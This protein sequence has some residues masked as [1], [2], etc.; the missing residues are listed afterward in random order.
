MIGHPIIHWQGEPGSLGISP[1]KLETK[2]DGKVYRFCFFPKLGLANKKSIV[3]WKIVNFKGEV[4]QMKLNFLGQ[5]LNFQLF[6]ITYLVGI[7]WLSEFNF[8]ILTRFLNTTSSM[9]A[10]ISRR[11]I[12]RYP[13][14]TTEVRA[15]RF[16][17]WFRNV[18]CTM[19]TKHPSAVGND[20]TQMRQVNHDFFHQI[21]PK[22]LKIWGVP[23]KKLVSHIW[24]H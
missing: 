12:F 13:P 16:D 1:N 7:H 10:S 21:F 3:N 24:S 17:P 6:G 22:C 18:H 4:L 11:I 5:W 2:N 9:D 23:L 8:W 19:E 20:L 14:W 15:T